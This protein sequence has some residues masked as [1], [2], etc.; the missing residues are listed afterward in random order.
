[1]SGLCSRED[2]LKAHLEEIGADKDLAE[3]EDQPLQNGNVSRQ[4]TG[5]SEAW[6]EAA[7]LQEAAGN[8]LGEDPS[9]LYIDLRPYMDR[10]PVTV[11]LRSLVHNNQ[12]HLANVVQLTTVHIILT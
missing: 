5:S 1:M 2:I 12:Q 10:A 9:N 4:H 11:R 8:A 3:I 7:A 6:T